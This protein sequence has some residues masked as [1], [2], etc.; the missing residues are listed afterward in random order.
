MTTDN[1]ATPKLERPRKLLTKVEK[2]EI[3]LKHKKTYQKRLSK[4]KTMVRKRAVIIAKEMIKGANATDAIVTA[5]YSKQTPV[6]QILNNQIVKQTF[7]S[8]LE[9][10]GLTDEAIAEK[11]K[12]LFN[13]KETKFFSDKG[14]VTETREVEAL[15]IQSDTTK[16]LLKV[17]GHIVDKSSVEVPGI[18]D[19]LD[20][21]AQRRSGGNP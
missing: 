15:Q 8:I 9:K 5:G 6:T 16:T 2:H 14:I 3:A 7:N 11:L 18:E 21:I 4:T 20:K 10:T 13:A 12:S 1:N 19:I 17:K